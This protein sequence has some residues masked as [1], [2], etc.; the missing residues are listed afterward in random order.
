[1]IYDLTND[2]DLQ[3]AKARLN[4]LYS[5]GKKVEIKEKKRKRTLKQNS[6]LHVLLAYF[7]AEVGHTIEESKQIFKTVNSEL[8]IYEKEG[9]KYYRSTSELDTGELTNCIEKFKMY[10]GEHGIILPDA[11]DNNHLDY[12]ENMIEKNSQFL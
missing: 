3:R 11:D 9:V 8:L 7:A 10:A 2:I 6:Y 1:M 5:Q 4:Y 12:A